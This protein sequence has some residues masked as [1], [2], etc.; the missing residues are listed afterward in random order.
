[1]GWGRKEVEVV[2]MGM[3][4]V[5]RIVDVLVTV[6]VVEDV[7]VVEAAMGVSVSVVVVVMNEVCS[8]CKSKTI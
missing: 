3:I 5:E 8:P 7:V 6:C 1:M 4:V 2:V